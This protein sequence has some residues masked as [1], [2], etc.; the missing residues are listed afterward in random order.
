MKAVVC[1]VHR[2]DV[3]SR[4][5][6]RV[7]MLARAEH[8]GYDIVVVAVLLSTAFALRRAHEISE[9]RIQNLRREQ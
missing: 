6:C 9:L 3:T 1:T 8:P 5:L 2:G 7:R 4:C